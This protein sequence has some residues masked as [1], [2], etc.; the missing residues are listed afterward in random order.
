MP[1]PSY[2][3][4]ECTLCL[5]EWMVEEN[6]KLKESYTPDERVALVNKFARLNTEHRT[7]GPFGAGIF[8]KVSGKPLIVGA[9]R[10]VPTKMSSA[11]AEVTV[12]TLAQQIVD[13]F[14]LGASHLPEYQLVVNWMPCTM[15]YGAIVW[16]GVRSI[17]LAGY[18]PEVEEWTGFDEGPVPGGEGI[19]PESGKEF[20]KLELEK[21]GITVE[22]GSPERRQEA[23]EGFKYF[24]SSGDI[25]YNARG[26]SEEEKG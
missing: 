17:L 12:I 18:G 22:V 15:C 13:T 25:V 19:D 26:F 14:D 8:E 24:K 2:L 11:H 7:G 9:N 20:W 10:V 1:T 23:I 21:R 4:K 3:Q 5:P 6:K 16:S